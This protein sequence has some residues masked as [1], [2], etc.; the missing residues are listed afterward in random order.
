MRDW[1][2]R[3]QSWVYLTGILASLALAWVPSA[4]PSAAILLD[5]W[6]MAWLGW[7]FVAESA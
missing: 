6:C 5:D 4:W 2:E 1:M 3:Q 7:R